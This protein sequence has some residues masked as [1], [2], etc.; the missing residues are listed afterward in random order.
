MTKDNN[1]VVSALNSVYYILDSV[2]FLNCFFASLIKGPISGDFIV[3]DDCI[4]L[5]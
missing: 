3:H 2:L 5:S 1:C 4:E